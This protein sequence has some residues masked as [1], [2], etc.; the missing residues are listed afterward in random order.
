MKRKFAILLAIGIIVGLGGCKSDSS[1][2]S[3]TANPPVNSPP[4]TNTIA[5]GSASFSP[6]SLTVAKGTTIT[7][8]ND[9]YATHTSTSDSQGW[10]TGDM[11][12]GTTRTTTFNTPGTF[13][14]HCTYHGSMGMVGTITVQ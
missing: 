8:R 9:D 5:M 1:N 13:K 4:S 7:W 3:G 11:I 10:D 12:A 6:S 14:Y 2:P